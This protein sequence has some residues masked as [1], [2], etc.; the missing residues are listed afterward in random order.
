MVSARDFTHDGS[1]GTDFIRVAQV[2]QTCYTPENCI[3][4]TD[5]ASLSC[6]P[7]PVPGPL[8]A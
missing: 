2:A 7:L 4:I 1:D 6:V 3:S 8:R 5:Q